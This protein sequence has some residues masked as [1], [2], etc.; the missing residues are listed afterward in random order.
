M[1]KLTAAESIRRLA[2]QYQAMVEAAD[3][4][5][6]IGKLEQTVRQATKQAADATAEMDGAKAELA[7]VKAD[8]TKAKAKA[9]EIAAEANVKAM[10][11]LAE[12]D[13]KA[14]AI[15]DGANSEAA[16][17][18]AKADIAKAKQAEDLAAQIS[19]LTSAKLRLEQDVNALNVA[20]AAAQAEAV[21]AED[22]IAKAQAKIAK[23][24]G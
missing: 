21:A 13:R 2:V 16:T 15:I 5:E 17:R 18:L 8:V 3:A 19:N 12:A 7:V 6:S 24:L 22:R 4:L 9:A 23:M 1:D 10:E 14:Q 11:I 20:N